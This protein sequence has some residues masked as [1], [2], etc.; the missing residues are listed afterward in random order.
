IDERLE[1]LSDLATQL[2]DERAA[3]R[4]GERVRVLVE[5][6]DAD[7]AVGRAEHQ[8]PEVDG[9]CLLAPGV[10]AVGDLVWGSVVD[11]EGVD[12][13]VEVEDARDQ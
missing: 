2:V 4:V 1:R 10:A 6:S 13:V 11:T 3:D 9:S 8:G 12:L 5:S 7:G